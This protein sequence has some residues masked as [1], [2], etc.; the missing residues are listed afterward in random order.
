MFSMEILAHS[1]LFEGIAMIISFLGVAVRGW[2]LVKNVLK[3]F[4]EANPRRSS[5]ISNFAYT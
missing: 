1:G 3:P 2:T 4:S 5:S